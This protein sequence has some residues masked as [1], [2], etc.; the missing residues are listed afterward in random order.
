MI[1]NLKSCR[2]FQ[3]SLLLAALLQPGFSAIPA[4]EK[5]LPDDTL[6]VVTA[7]DFAKLRNSLKKLPLT[8]FWD[9]PAM[10]PFRENFLSKWNDQFVK[11]LEREL[12]IKI[13]DYT[14]LMQGQITFALTRDGMDNTGQ[15]AGLLLLLDTKDQSDKLK[16]QLAAL[17][18][19]WVDGGKALKTTKIRDNEFV[20][21]S[22]SSNDIPKTL[23]QFFPKSSQVHELGDDNAEPK[24]DSEADDLIIG[25]VD[26]LLILSSSTKAVE[27]VVARLTGGS[28]P[29]LADVAAYQADHAAF[30]REA[31]LYGWVNLKAAIDSISSKLA[32][33]KENPDAPNPFDVKPEKVLN[34]LG[35]AGLKTLAASY[36][37]A[38]DGTM[39]K[40]SV[41]V[42]ESSRRGIFR[43]LAGEPRD[44][45][46][47]AFVP[48]DAVRFQRWRID[49][50]K[51]WETLQ[52]AVADIS[53]Q[54]VN[55]INFLID[56]ANTAARTKDPGFDIKKNIIGNLGDDMITYEKAPLGK[57]PAQLQSPPSIFLLGSPN[58]EV[59]AASLKSVL[60]FASQ[61]AETTAED[62]EFLGR[63]IYTVSLKSVMG[64][65]G[66]GAAT[67]AAANLSYTASGGY[68]A[69]STNPSL[70]EEYLRS[71]ETQRKALKETTGLAEAAQK[72]IGPGS[73]LFGY[74]N[75]VETMRTLIENLRKNGSSASPPSSN[76]AANLLPSGLNVPATVRSFKELMDFSLLPN[77]DSVSKYFHFSVYGG[78]ANVDGLVFKMFNPNPPGLK[79]Q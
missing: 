53:P 73:S 47:P 61:Q 5:L 59:F 77:F 60:S 65:L 15:P 76:P 58:A 50:Q 3:A 11:P 37:S 48:A 51:T 33:R 28:V 21:V 14:N 42:P 56:T 4:P 79:N 22:L 64:P 31:P 18:K 1:F 55:A 40:V 39:L 45:R 17:R 34:A 9:D 27:K 32:E 44:A 36:Q 19:K 78:E 72:V 10:K 38:N 63:K 46:P 24:N 69:F 71:S 66:G 52:K 74:E 49:G 67:P 41:G 68:V 54:W 7:P 8:Q 6:V 13:E 2:V 25:Q 12:D 29:P 75:Q 35:L 30:F 20:T 62:R 23:R 16:K 26:S 43:I 70:L 57:S